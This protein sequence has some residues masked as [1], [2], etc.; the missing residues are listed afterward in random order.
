M[1]PHRLLF[2]GD[3]NEVEFER[4]PGGRGLTRPLAD[5][6][7]EPVSLAQAFEPRGEVDRIPHRGIG[8]ALVRAHVADHALAG[9]DADANVDRMKN[10]AGRLGLS[11]E[12]AV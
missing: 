2:A 5:D 1:D 12:L 3:R 10:P 9:V 8:E 4:G 6:D 7:R 11:L